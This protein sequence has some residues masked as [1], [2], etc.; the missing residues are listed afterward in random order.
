VPQEK[1]KK[2]VFFFLSQMLVVLAIQEVEIR[3]Y[4]KNPHHKKGLVEWPKLW[5]LSSN[6]STKK[7]SIPHTNQLQP[8]KM[9]IPSSLLHDTK[10]SLTLSS[11]IVVLQLPIIKSR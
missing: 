6:P 11:V 8:G 3:P 4:L 5:A 7:K 9:D 2:K 10:K 1:K